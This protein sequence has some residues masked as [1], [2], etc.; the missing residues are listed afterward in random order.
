MIIIKINFCVGQTRRAPN[1]QKFEEDLN[2]I[3][4]QIEAKEQ[5][6]VIF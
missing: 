1:R 6:L 3:K 2:E 4:Q 5:H